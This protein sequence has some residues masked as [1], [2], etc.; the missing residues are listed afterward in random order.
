M[1]QQIVDAFKHAIETIRI[2]V[3]KK[4]DVHRMIRRAE[5]IGDEL[6]PKGRAADS[7]VQHM[8]ETFSIFSRYFSGVNIFSEVFDAVN[9]ILD[10]SPKF[11]RRRER[12][13]PKPIMTNHAV[14]SRIGDL[15]RFQLAHRCKCLFDLRLHLLEKIIREF[16]PADI[17]RKTELPIF[18]EI[19]LKPLPE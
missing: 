6:R 8:R 7:Y 10:F 4:I 11:C 16:H 17:E 12:G 9:R 18:Q 19:S 1:R 3:V 13:I 15:A 5:R 2:G 14:F